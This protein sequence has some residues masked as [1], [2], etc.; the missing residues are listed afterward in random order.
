M[1][2]YK[3]LLPHILLEKWEP[4]FWTIVD[5]ENGTKYAIIDEVT[6]VGRADDARRHLIDH[7]WYNPYILVV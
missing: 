2:R 1:N 4:C 6:Y 7:D 5:E 3:V